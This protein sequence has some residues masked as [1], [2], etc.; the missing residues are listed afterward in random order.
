MPIPPYNG[1]KVAKPFNVKWS[2][3]NEKLNKPNGGVYNILGFGIPA[4]HDFKNGGV[5]FNTCPG[6]LACKAVCYAKQG[7]YVKPNVVAARK[8]NL[9]RSM[10]A[11]FIQKVVDDLS[12]FKKV[13]VVRIHDSGDFYSQNYLDKWIAIARA[14][15]HIIFY[16]YTKSLKLDLSKAPANLRITQS[17]G[18]KHDG[19]VNLNR[20]HSRIFASEEARVNAGYEDG[21]SNDVPAIEGVVRNGLVYHGTKNLTDSQKKYFS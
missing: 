21:S 11:G 2:D 10:Q 13:N 20:P 9:K 12:R 5:K 7:H 17:L 4:D 1:E 16:A 19:L 15:P 8:H 6:A 18:G 14:V 3:G